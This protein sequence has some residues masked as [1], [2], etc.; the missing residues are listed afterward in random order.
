MFILIYT[1]TN[2]PITQSVLLLLR[3]KNKIRHSLV[4]NEFV[5]DYILF[6]VFFPKGF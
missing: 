6:E 4:A 5:S 3:R 2:I 1:G